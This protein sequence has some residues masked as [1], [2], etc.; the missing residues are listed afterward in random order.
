MFTFL[1]LFVINV[2]VT[3]V[4]MKFTVSEGAPV[5]SS[6]PSGLQSAGPRGR[7][8]GRELEPDRRADRASTPRPSGAIRDASSVTARSCCG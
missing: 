7:R 4:G 5:S 1:A 8:T 3:A 6:I 2:I